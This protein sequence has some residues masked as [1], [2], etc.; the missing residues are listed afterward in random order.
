MFF[1]LLID[2]LEL[3]H[4]CGF[5]P[6]A[7]FLSKKFLTI[8]FKSLFF[9]FLMVIIYLVMGKRILLK[10][11]ISNLGKTYPFYGNDP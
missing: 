7:T 2:G 1:S 9:H 6:R 5:C 10:T 11:N 3:N 8:Q 4:F